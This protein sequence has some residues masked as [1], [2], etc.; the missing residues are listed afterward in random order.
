MPD[1]GLVKQV[2]LGTEPRPQMRDVFVMVKGK[3]KQIRMK[4]TDFV[5]WVE[6][7][8]G[9][10]LQTANFMRR[11]SGSNILRFMATAGN[12]EFA[13]SN[14]ARDMA[15]IWLVT[16]EF[17][18]NAFK[19]IPQMG[20]DMFHV[21]TDAVGRKGAYLD[22]INEGGGM[23]FLTHQGR[24]TEKTMGALA[25]FQK[26]V[27]YMGETSEIMTRLALRRRALTNL[28]KAGGIKTA[29]DML[30]AQRQATWEA[31]N[32]LD[33]SQ[34]GSAIKAAD[35]AIPYLNASIQGT[36]GLFRAARANPKA[37]IAKASQVMALSA[38]LYAANRFVNPKTL[39]QVSDPRQEEQLHHTIR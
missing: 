16:D 29:D 28:R 6:R 12:P 32:F 39:A 37:F 1:N 2:K 25:N 15:H 20:S 14:L 36:R 26:V 34:G 30:L 35:N 21:F 33:F 23:S 7:D 10:S 8:T 5:E 4:S 17:S 24:I 38:G 22:Y 3:P 18:K 27:S 13:V 19:A 9:V 11:W 31:R